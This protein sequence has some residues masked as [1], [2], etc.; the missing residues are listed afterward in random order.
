MVELS[1]GLH[2]ES[3]DRLLSVHSSSFFNP[4]QVPCYLLARL[5]PPRPKG[6]V[7]EWELQMD[8]NGRTWSGRERTLSR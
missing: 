8:K 5:S 4:R 6:I 1:N 3:G 2:G 7:A